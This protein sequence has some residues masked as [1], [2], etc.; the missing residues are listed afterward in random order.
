MGFVGSGIQC[1]SS[2]SL[3]KSSKN[4][5]ENRTAGGTQD[6]LKIERFSACLFYTT[7]PPG[8]APRD[9][10]RHRPYPPATK[11]STKRESARR[12]LADSLFV[13]LP[14]FE[15]RQAE[16][17][18]AVLPLHHKTILFAQAP[19]HLKRHKVRHLCGIIQIFLH[20]FIF[21]PHGF[22]QFQVSVSRF[23]FPGFGFP[24]PFPIPNSWF[25]IT[26]PRL[27]AFLTGTEETVQIVARHL[28]HGARPH[29]A[30]GGH[31]LHYGCYLGLGQLVGLQ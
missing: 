24:I 13:V 11:P 1:R 12:C 25:P 27:R 3:S 31:R 5:F 21:C 17:K 26:N 2:Q 7:K 29:G 20:F 18:T 30:C 15:P 23:P 6:R 16:P 22:P 19:A 28:R 9:L 14:G 4:W 10:H 8:T